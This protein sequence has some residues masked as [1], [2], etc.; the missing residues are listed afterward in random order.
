MK[1]TFIRGEEAGDPDLQAKACG[2][3][4]VT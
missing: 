1:E 4:T 2:K 3:M